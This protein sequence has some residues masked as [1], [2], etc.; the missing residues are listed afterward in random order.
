[1]NTNDRFGAAIAGGRREMYL[2]NEVSDESILSTVMGPSTAGAASRKS[3]VRGE[4]LHV[5]STRVTVHRRPGLGP[6]DDYDKEVAVPAGVITKRNG[7]PLMNFGEAFCGPHG[8][9]WVRS[10][11]KEFHS[12]AEAGVVKHDFEQVGQHRPSVMTATGIMRHEL[13]SW[14]ESKLNGTVHELGPN[15]FRYATDR[16]IQLGRLSG[17]DPTSDLLDGL[18]KDKKTL[19]SQRQSA[20]CERDTDG[21]VGQAHS[22]CRDKYN[23]EDLEFYTCWMMAIDARRANASVNWDVISAWRE[24][25][26]WRISEIDN[27]NQGGRPIWR[28]S[29]KSRT[30]G[31]S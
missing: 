16:G 28:P 11:D 6:P 8:N 10:A 15:K 14:E 23:N 5:G 19:Q 18:M 1:M 22:V 25:D 4:L 26:A 3:S 9:E 17:G 30:T 21:N 24:Y 29:K 7:A 13:T 2:A 27:A 12:F 20:Q 31:Y